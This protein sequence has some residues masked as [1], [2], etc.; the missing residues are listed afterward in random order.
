MTLFIE[1]GHLTRLALNYVPAGDAFVMVGM[2]E[3]F[4]KLRK[5][6][7]IKDAA[8]QVARIGWVE[9][10]E[11]LPG[12]PNCMENR[13]GGRQVATNVLWANG[14]AGG[15]RIVQILMRW[16]LHDYHEGSMAAVRHGKIEV[17]KLFHEWGG[18]D[19][20]AERILGV[21]ALQGEIHMMRF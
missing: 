11:S 7:A 16:E 10:L 6:I 17:L 20:D 4:R 18:N 15:S 21:A 12:H 3:L 1:A 2:H 8:N 5:N 13:I 9:G 19:I 14:V